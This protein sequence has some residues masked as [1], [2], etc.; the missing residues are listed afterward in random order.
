MDLIELTVVKVNGKFLPAS[1]LAGFN[2]KDIVSPI[3]S[4]TVNSVFIGKTLTEIPN[5]NQ[6]SGHNTYEVSESL[7]TI[8]VMSEKLFLGDVIKRNNVVVSYQAIFVAEIVPGPLNAVTAGTQFQYKETGAINL[9]NYIVTETIAQIVAQTSGQGE[10]WALNGN[11][12][13]AEKFIGTINNFDFPV[14]TANVER[15]RTNAIGFGINVNPPIFALDVHSTRNSLTAISRFGNTGQD[16]KVFAND[17]SPEGVITADHGD[18]CVI[19]DGTTGDF[20]QKITGTGNT[21]WA[22]I[23][24][25]K[26][27]KISLTAAQLKTGNSV[28]IVAVPAPGA[29]KYIRV[30]AASFNYVKNDGLLSLTDIAL[31]IDTAPGIQYDSD[32]NINPAASTFSI[33]NAV[34]LSIYVGGPPVSIIANKALTIQ[35]DVDSVA[36]TGTMDVYITYEIITV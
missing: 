7:A 34:N 22:Q 14:R 31:I 1:V 26:R 6:N 10:F 15:T 9:I 35:T 5:T 36:G 30:N 19:D 18:I 29:G 17:S 33:L 11:T 21:G 32:S 23:G 13:S 2:V 20:Y 4:N 27:V 25:S 24:I 28:P 8:S 3:T 12:V 16:F